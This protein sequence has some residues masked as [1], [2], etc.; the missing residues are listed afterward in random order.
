[1]STRVQSAAEIRP[2]QAEIP[3]E[4]IDDLRSR[5]AA[6]RW[7]SKELVDDRSQGV[8][9]ATLKA[10]A[11]YWTGDYDFRRVAERLN[12]VPQFTTEIDGVEI[13]F[14]HVRSQHEG[15]LPLIM[16][17]GW[18]GSVIELLDTIGP[19]T[20]PTAHGAQAQDA[21]HLVLPSLPG[22]GFSGEPAET[23]W[24]TGRVAQ[25][26]AELMQ[27]LGY[28]RFVAQGGDQG[29]A[30]TDDMA[31]Q[32]PEGLIGVHLNLL[33]TALGSTAGL[34]TESDQERAA[35]EAVTTFRTSGF[36]YFLEQS[37]RPQTIGYALLD[38]PVALAGW[39]IDHDT[40]SYYKISRAFVDDEPADGLTRDHI[41]DNITLY[42]LTATGASAARSYWEGG[43]AAALAA[44]QTPPAVSLPVGFTTFPG[45]IFRAPRSWVEKSYP[46]VVYFNE[47]EKGGHFA[48]WEEP[49]LFSQELRAAFG[50]LR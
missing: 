32:A 50:S 15:A 38:S 11:D 42:W 41:L 26:W 29:A 40:D 13:H 43:R 21:F 25:A 48:A 12:A 19:L 34:P 45:E 37:T 44:G 30:V 3:E 7:P 4:Q 18:P 10:L 49:E 9:L 24:Y 36:G 27:R 46:N 2:F 39:M 16:T 22:Y 20:D 33:R 28:T 14:I 35:L 23:G 17:H 47:A 6:T 1:M 5:I 8:Q 31:R